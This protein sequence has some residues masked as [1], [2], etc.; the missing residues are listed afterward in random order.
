MPRE[1]TF[2][3]IIRFL[4]FWQLYIF[5][6]GGFVGDGV[7]QVANGIEPGLLLVVG[8]NREPGRPVTYQWQ[9]TFR[10]VRVNSRTSDCRI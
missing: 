10:P 8:A 5:P 4:A 9:R 2:L 1:V 7:E 6:R 3:I